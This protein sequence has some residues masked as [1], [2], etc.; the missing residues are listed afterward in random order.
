MEP[1]LRR[2]L[3]AA[4]IDV[5]DITNPR[6]AWETLHERHGPATTVVDRYALEAHHRGIEVA[7]LSIADRARL[8]EEVLEIR[9][10]GIEL[11]GEPSGHPIVVVPYDRN[12][13][14][15]FARWR[16]RIEDAI[17]S[18]ART[19]HHIGS[20]AV[21]QLAAKPIIDI[22]VG[23][24]HL[25]DEG[26]YVAGIASTGV[27]LRSRDPEHRYFR[28]AADR[29]REVQIHVCTAGGDWHHNYVLF[30]DYLRSS[31]AIRDDYAALKQELAM[32]YSGDR[33]AYT[34]AKAA[35]I[36]NRLGE[37]QRWATAT[38]WTLPS[39]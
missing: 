29:P 27:L 9:F 17:G 30:R 13:P 25:E 36:L 10:P 31:P 19:I 5:H 3:E 14:R 7:D 26:S 20:T 18:A 24:D 22:V 21:P 2:R 1:E 39:E 16:R 11:I 34:D 28:P 23:V 8:A 37:A 12:W 38:D 6:L 33:I 32:R 15:L 35:F 4:G